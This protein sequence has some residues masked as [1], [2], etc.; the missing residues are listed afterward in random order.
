[1]LIENTLDVSYFWYKY[2]NCKKET[3]SNELSSCIG[4]YLYYSIS[5]MRAYNLLINICNN[6]IILR[7]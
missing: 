4:A 5:D 7:L 1:M 6:K 3:F 2:Y